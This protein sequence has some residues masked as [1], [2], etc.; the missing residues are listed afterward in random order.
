M[1]GKD[2]RG[3]QPATA[4]PPHPPPPQH[5]NLP[6]YFVKTDLHILR[7]LGGNMVVTLLPANLWVYASELNKDFWRTWASQKAVLIPK[8]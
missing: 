7:S 5:P 4:H 6:D 2:M 3:R 8:V 1:L